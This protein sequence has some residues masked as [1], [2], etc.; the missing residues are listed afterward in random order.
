MNKI[1]INSIDKIIIKMF[2]MLKI[3]YLVPKNTHDIH[4]LKYAN[5]FDI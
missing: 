1:N 4:K 2:L 3:C 5:C